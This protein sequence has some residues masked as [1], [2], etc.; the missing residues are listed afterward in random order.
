LSCAHNA[1]GRYEIIDEMRRRWRGHPA[2]GLDSIPA[3]SVTYRDE[4]CIRPCI[5]ADREHSARKN[6]NRSKK[7]SRCKRLPDGISKLTQQKQ[8]ALSI[9][10]WSITQSIRLIGLARWVMSN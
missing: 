1:E 4:S 9:S 6:L 10:G 7:L 3:V 8:V 5:G 2:A